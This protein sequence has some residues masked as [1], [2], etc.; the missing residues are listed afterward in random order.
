ML[1]NNNL[2]IVRIGYKNIY[3]IFAAIVIQELNFTWQILNA[4]VQSLFLS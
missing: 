3:N 1:T 2:H 4:C